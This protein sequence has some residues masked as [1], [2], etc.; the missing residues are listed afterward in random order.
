ME[1]CLAQG[2]EANVRP[3]AGFR[4]FDLLLVAMTA[5]KQ[6]IENKTKKKP[7]KKEKTMKRK[8][9]ESAKRSGMKMQK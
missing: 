2:K 7:T 9:V 8:I 3:C 6:R 4:S 5:E 1:R